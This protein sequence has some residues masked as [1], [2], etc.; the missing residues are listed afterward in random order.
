[1]AKRQGGG[2]AAGVVRMNN[3]ANA[4]EQA[5]ASEYAGEVGADWAFSTNGRMFA[6][7][8]RGMRVRMDGPLTE[9]PGP[10]ALEPQIPLLRE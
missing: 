4:T 3:P 7:G 5:Q 9:F 10:G 2:N 6:G 1:M 8:R